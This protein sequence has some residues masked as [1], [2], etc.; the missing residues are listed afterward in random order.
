AAH[1]Y[2]DRF[3]LGREADGTPDLVGSRSRTAGRVDAHDHRA[4]TV[5]L[6][7]LLKGPFHRLR[8]HA[9]LAER[10]G[11][12]VLAAD[13]R[14][15]RIDDGNFAFRVHPQAGVFCRH[16]NIA[17]H[18]DGLQ[19]VVLVDANPLLDD[20]HDLI[21]EEESVD[22]SVLVRLDGCE[23]GLRLHDPGEL[24]CGLAAALG[25]RV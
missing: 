24:V 22:E 6:A 2:D 1:R 10:A 25:D 13:D 23:H 21:L 14:A 17:G 18:R 8:A 5:V 16:A 20:V 15:L 3:L 11:A 7:G 9:L 4:D 19:I 12:A